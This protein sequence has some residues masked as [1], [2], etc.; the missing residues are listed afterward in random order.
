[1]KKM[2]LMLLVSLLAF[3]TKAQMIK[4]GKPI[5]SGPGGTQT[6][7]ETKEPVPFEFKKQ[8]MIS[9]SMADI[10]MTNLTAKYDFFSK[11][12]NW[13]FQIP[14]SFNLGGVPDS[15]DYRV[16]NAGR[17]I[18]AKNRIF[19]SGIN[20]NYYLVGQQKVSPFVGLSGAAG[21]FYYWKY[22]YSPQVYPYYYGGQQA[23]EHEKLIGTNASFAFHAGFL[24]NPW[25][26]LTF[27]IKGGVGL[28]RYTT[29]YKEFTYPFG[30]LDFSLGFKF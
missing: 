22:T 8:S 19:Q 24:F 21:W 7:R 27:S 14:L 13:G 5:G 29:I 23:L 1:M 20:F 26:T 2:I 9:L 3:Q 17:F 15:N 11:K 30:L 12:G 4:K 6:V 25:E 10:V 16:N 18:S 28:R